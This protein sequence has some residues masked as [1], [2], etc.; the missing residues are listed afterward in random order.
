MA[1]ETLSMKPLKAIN[2][3]KGTPHHLSSQLGVFFSPPGGGSCHAKRVPLG[4]EVV[5]F[6][7]CMLLDPRAAS[8]WHPG[9]ERMAMVR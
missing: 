8:I 4:S 9:R 7:H 2:C 5:S 3:F 6:V 1:N